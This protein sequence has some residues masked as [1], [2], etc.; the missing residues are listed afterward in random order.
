M[1]KYF[2]ILLALFIFNPEAKIFQPTNVKSK[3]E[4][5]LRSEGIKTNVYIF[6]TSK[7]FKE[8]VNRL[9]PEFAIVNSTGNQFLLVI[10]M[11]QNLIAKS[12]KNRRIFKKN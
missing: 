7:D 6:V 4:T 9:K 8:S 10:T 12:L 3:L 1:K 5:F 11:V 2:E